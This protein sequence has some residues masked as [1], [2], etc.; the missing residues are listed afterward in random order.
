VSGQL[1]GVWIYLVGPFV[2]GAIG[3]AAYLRFRQP[4]VT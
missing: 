1:D 3:G 2:G 4:A